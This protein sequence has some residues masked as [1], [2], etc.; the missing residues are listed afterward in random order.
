LVSSLGKFLSQKRHLPEWANDQRSAPI[1]HEN[2]LAPA[3]R[4]TD[5]SGP[6]LVYVW[7]QNGVA[8]GQVT[9]NSPAL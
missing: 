5:F 9:V 1:L 6:D 4:A 2:I 8:L 7:L 3:V